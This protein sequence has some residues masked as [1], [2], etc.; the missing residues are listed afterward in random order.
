MLLLK[1]TENN[2]LSAYPCKALHSLNDIKL[3]FEN[4]LNIWKIWIFPLVDAQYQLQ[5]KCSFHMCK[6][7]LFSLK[8]VWLILARFV[9]KGFL[10]KC[11]VQNYIFILAYLLNVKN[12]CFAHLGS[13]GWIGEESKVLINFKNCHKT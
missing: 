8:N 3:Y 10:T 4:Y 2:L 13:E 1:L 5:S 6:S 12:M 11:K 9:D 7:I